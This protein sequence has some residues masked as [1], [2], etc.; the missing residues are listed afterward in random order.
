M[1]YVD[2]DVYK[3]GQSDVTLYAVWICDLTTVTTYAGAI[4]SPLGGNNDSGGSALNARFWLPSGIAFDTSDNL[5][6]ADSYNNRIRKVILSTGQMAADIGPIDGSSG[7]DGDYPQNISMAKLNN[8]IGICI[9]PSGDIIFSDSSNHRLRKVDQARGRLSTIAG[10][11]TAGF[12]GENISAT[13][14]SVELNNPRDVTVYNGDIYFADTGNMRIRKIN[15]EGKISTVAGGGTNNYTVNGVSATSAY[16]VDLQGMV[17]DSDGNLYISDAGEHV[18]RKIDHAT[19][20]IY[21]IAGDGTAGYTGDGIQITNPNIVQLYYP[22]GLAVDKADNLY[23]ADSGNNVV[24]M[25]NHRTDIITTVVG[26]Y[27]S[28]GS[29]SYTNN[30]GALIAKLNKPDYI[31][32]DSMGRLYI[33][34]FT[35]CIIRKVE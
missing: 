17:F 3:V 2:G 26:Q 34:E 25:I 31:K 8:P 14:V 15:S 22:V 9:L 10:K 32:F 35:Q 1:R 24:R 20:M 13:D 18:I 19:G 5:Y 28:Y 29:Y 7:F 27:Y 4:L 16:L 11:G 23:I 33:S 12:G 30:T 21:T 6:I